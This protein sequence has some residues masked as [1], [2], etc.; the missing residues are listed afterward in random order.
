MHAPR[1][2]PRRR[3]RWPWQS[4][5]QAGPRCFKCARS[6]AA[7][8]M[9]AAPWRF[10]ACVRRTIRPVAA[11]SDPKADCRSRRQTRRSSP[12]PSQS[13]HT[14]GKDTCQFRKRSSVTSSRSRS[15]YLL[16]PGCLRSVRCA[17]V[18][19]SERNLHRIAKLPVKERAQHLR[20][21]HDSEGR[22]SQRRE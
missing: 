16:E 10:R 1:G 8:Q 12:S 20:D 19:R 13:D 9:R 14:P 6:C 7:G 22:A 3:A 21:R 4:L 15:E 17:I 11:S 18:R 2:Q 5:S